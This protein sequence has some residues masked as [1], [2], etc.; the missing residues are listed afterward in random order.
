[1]ASKQK[2]GL[3]RTKI[4]IGVDA[5]G[6]PINKWISGTTKKELEEA[7][8]QAVAH[9]IDSTALNDDRMFGEYAIEWYNINKRPFVS[10]STHNGYRTMLN[11]YILP[12]FGMRKLRAIRHAEIQAFVNDF[13]G[14][15][16]SQIIN[17]ISLLNGIFAA[18]KADRIIQTNPAE[19]IRK[20]SAT[21]PKEKLAFT[22]E[23]RTRITQQFTTHEHGDYLAVM[24]YTGMRPGEVRGLKWE[25]FDWDRRLIHVQRDIDYAG[26]KAEIGALKTKSADRYIPIADDLKNILYPKRQAPGALLF[27]GNGGKPLSEAT[28]RRW[29]ISLMIACGMAQET[30]VSGYSKNDLRGQYKTD[31]TPHAMRHNFITMCWEQGM[32]ILLTMKIVGHADYQ[33]TRN[34]YTHLSAKHLDNAKQQLD[35]MFEKSCTKVAQPSDVID[36]L[37]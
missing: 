3:Y 6:K 28:A 29:W 35:A 36:F 37:K 11:K 12:A 22:N 23:E 20:P 2:S 26:G 32:D 24:Y 10:A 4:K 16:K 5:D 19:N 8:Q 17:A 31:I 25:D 7:R 21:P 1:M 14:K 33:T 18:A 15:S 13:A 30:P 9:Y 27:S 34:I